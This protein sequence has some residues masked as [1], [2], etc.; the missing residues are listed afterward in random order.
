MLNSDATFHQGSTHLIC[1]DYAL[2]RNNGVTLA[3]LADGCSSSPNTDTGARLL[4]HS[5]LRAVDIINIKPDNFT[6]H[7]TDEFHKTAVRFGMLTADSLGLKR[8]SLDATLL[9][10]IASEESNRVVVTAYG[11]GVVAFKFKGINSVLVRTI[12]YAQNYPVYPSYAVQPDRQAGVRQIVGNDRVMTAFTTGPE[13]LNFEQ[14]GE[15]PTNLDFVQWTPNKEDLEF[16]AI[17]S[18]GANTFFEKG[19]DGR[20]RH[21]PLTEFAVELLDFRR[22]N[23]VFV[24]RRIKAFLRDKA[25]LGWH[26]K[27]DFAIAAVAF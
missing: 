26:H 6:E 11:D 22:Y 17:M 10:I 27:D 9:S 7:V 13:Q 16:V 24:E 12:E 4:V 5:A 23:G 20:E 14:I 18:D 1:Q 19:S 8:E 3:L 21:I 25:K 15:P 2:Q